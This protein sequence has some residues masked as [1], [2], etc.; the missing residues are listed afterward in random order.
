MGNSDGT[1]HFLAHFLSGLADLVRRRGRPAKSDVTLDAKTARYCRRRNRTLQ[2][3]A[4]EPV[5]L[6]RKSI[7]ILKKETITSGKKNKKSVT[8]GTVSFI[9]I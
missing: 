6:S 9:F 5:A 2:K 7:G 8:L 3:A 1:E 4:L